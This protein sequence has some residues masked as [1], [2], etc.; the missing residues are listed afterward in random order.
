MINIQD[1]RSTLWADAEFMTDEEIQNV[2][3]LLRWVC[4]MVIDEYFNTKYATDIKDTES[5][6][7]D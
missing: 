7:E 4:R 1:A 5:E 3:D 2:I 6:K